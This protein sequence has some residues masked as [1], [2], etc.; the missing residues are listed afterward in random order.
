LTHRDLID[1]KKVQDIR[2]IAHSKRA[3]PAKRFTQNAEKHQQ[4]T[5]SKQSQ[6]CNLSPIHGA[7][8]HPNVDGSKETQWNV[9]LN[10]EWLPGASYRSINQ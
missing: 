5:I 6:K 2:P 4:T 9:F 7:I 10:P 3:R 1:P 8:I